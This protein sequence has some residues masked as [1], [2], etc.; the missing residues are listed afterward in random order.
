ML[1]YYLYEKNDVYNIF[2]EE[3]LKIRKKI[4]KP[5]FIQK[6]SW[7]LLLSIYFVYIYAFNYKETVL[8]VGSIVICL[9]LAI[10]LINI[11]FK[12]YEVS[13]I[14]PDPEN[15]GR[16]ALYN[17]L[18]FKKWYSLIFQ[19]LLILSIY[20]YLNGS[21]SYGKLIIILLV[22][23]VIRL[24]FKLGINKARMSLIKFS[25]ESVCEELNTLESEV[26]DLEEYLEAGEQLEFLFGTRYS[27]TV[28]EMNKLLKKVLECTLKEKSSLYSKSQLVSNLSHDLKTPLTSIINSVYILKYDKLDKDEKNEQIKIIQEK[29]D[30]LKTLIENLNEVIMSEENEIILNKENIDICKLIEDCIDSFKT[31]LEES[32]LDIRINKPDED[33]IAYLDKDKTIRVFENLISNIVKYSL[34]DTRVYIEILQEEEYI[35]VTLKNI[36][37]YELEV[38]KNTLG[39]RFVKGDKSRHNEGYGLGLSIVKNLMKVHGGKTSISVEGDLFKVSINIKNT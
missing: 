10:N 1:E 19:G 30:R 24:F 34:E 15:E 14:E 4:T 29:T 36:S 2:E 25:L 5:L 11:L 12:T 32:N 3:D 38:D 17:L 16:K 37:K 21:E 23:N 20:K 13:K 28:I 27:I 9:V 31:R 39:N 35:K 26:M 22:I 7:M 33:I 6:F 8:L 18:I